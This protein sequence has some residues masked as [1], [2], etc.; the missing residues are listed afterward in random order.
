MKASPTTW[1]FTYVRTLTTKE[2]VDMAEGHLSGAARRSFIRADLVMEVIEDNRPCYAAVEVSYTV[3]ARDTSRA[4]R[5]A[6]YI[7]Q[8]TGVPCYP[9]IVG[10]R[11]DWETAALVDAGT[12]RWSE[13]ED[14]NQP[15]EE[16]LS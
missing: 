11:K 12:V 1:D 14:W 13:I 9:G 3:D 4:I 2:L 10:V 16:G 8:F 6:G 5:N 15:A 7:T